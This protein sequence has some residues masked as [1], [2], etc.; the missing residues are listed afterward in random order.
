MFVPA[1][2]S[3]PAIVAVLF[4]DVTSYGQRNIFWCATCMLNITVQ[5]LSGVF[6]AYFILV[7]IIFHR[8][9]EQ[10]P[11]APLS[12]LKY[13]CFWSYLVF[14]HCVF[15]VAVFAYSICFVHKMKTRQKRKFLFCAE[16]VTVLLST[17]WKVQRCCLSQVD[18]I[19]SS[20]EC[21]FVLA[22]VFVTSVHENINKCTLCGMT[23]SS[24][25]VDCLLC[26]I[27][28]TPLPLMCDSGCI[29]RTL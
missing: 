3:L 25:A 5:L 10:L 14:L 12:S 9:L 20:L 28:V 26:N 11:P 1:S 2:S 19:S 13:I 18:F 23:V 4:C 17:L 22:S 6:S 21:C 27:L 7:T 8:L 16:A 15:H 24:I 29:S